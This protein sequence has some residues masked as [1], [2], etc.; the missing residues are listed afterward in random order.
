MNSLIKHTL[1]KDEFI[2]FHICVQNISFKVSKEGGGYRIKR[3]SEEGELECSRIFTPNM[4]DFNIKSNYQFTYI[5]HCKRCKI[6]QNN[7]LYI[8]KTTEYEY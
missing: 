6:I 5:S 1:K 3:Y 4:N 8:F 2:I 7:K